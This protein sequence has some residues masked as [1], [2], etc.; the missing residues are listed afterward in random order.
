[1]ALSLL[2]SGSAQCHTLIQG[3]IIADLCGFSN[4]NA[5]SVVDKEAFSDFCTRMDFNAGF[6]HRAL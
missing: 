1:M 5:V 4:D 2:L 3:H 6:A